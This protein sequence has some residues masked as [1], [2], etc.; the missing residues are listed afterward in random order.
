MR[1]TQT[2]LVW[3]TEG[4]VGAI[5]GTRRGFP[6][7]AI[8]VGVEPVGVLVV[9]RKAVAICVPLRTDRS[10]ELDFSDLHAV[11]STGI[12]H[13]R[14]NNHVGAVND[15]VLVEFYGLQVGVIQSRGAPRAATR[16]ESKIARSNKGEVGDRKG[17]VACIDIGPVNLVAGG[18]A[19]LGIVSS[20]EL[21]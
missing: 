7:R 20:P 13:S 18:I 10:V 1:I 5:H 9:I 4:A 12:F 8:V 19:F 6:N 15:R 11:C 17:S 2:I 3:I 14:K 21:Q 16:W